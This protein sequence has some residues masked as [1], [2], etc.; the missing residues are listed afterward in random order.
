[1]NKIQ[2]A[3]RYLILILNFMLV[4]V[5]VFLLIQWFLY[6]QNN[7]RGLDS[8]N[9][10]LSF[11]RGINT[12]EGYVL[13]QSVNWSPTSL[14]IGFLADAIGLILFMISLIL[15]R[16]IFRTYS[17]SEIFS[18]HNA[19]L[20]K[21]LGWLFLIDAFLAH[22]LSESL[23][24]LATTL[25]NQSGHRYLS[26]SFGTPNLEQI[27]YGTIVII[28]SWIMQEASKINDDQKLTI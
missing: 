16:K 19:A 27:F 9:C 7:M 13:L 11:A 17:K 12:P 15:L 20:Y 23:M 28:I 22:P 1:M 2:T 26:L 8:V 3:S 21:K 14:L 6:S 5:P 18:Q 10:I 4:I 24:I 25:N